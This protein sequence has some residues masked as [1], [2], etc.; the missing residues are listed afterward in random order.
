MS[1]LMSY[2]DLNPVGVIDTN[3]WDLKAA[4]VNW[5]FRENALYTPLLDWDASGMSTGAVN[6]VETELLEGD[7]DSNPI[8]LTANFIDAEG[9]DS[10]SRRFSVERHGR[11]AA[12]LC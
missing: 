10:R 5:Q 6:T 4:E 11:F 2:Y 1:D 12:A 3:V 9:L 7:V 8:P